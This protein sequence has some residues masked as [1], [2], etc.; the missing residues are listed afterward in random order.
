MNWR[1]ALGDRGLLKLHYM[2]AGE[3]EAYVV[4]S[5]HGRVFGSGMAS[6]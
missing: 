6:M 3:I 2:K 1:N 5:L 4:M